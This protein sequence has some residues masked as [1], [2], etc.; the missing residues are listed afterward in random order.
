MS[1]HHLAGQDGIR[2]LGRGRLDRLDGGDA[3]DPDQLR[4][5]ANPLFDKALEQG[6]CVAAS[7][8]APAG[9]TRDDSLDQGI[10]LGLGDGVI[11]HHLRRPPSGPRP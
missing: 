10:D 9:P 2:L 4:E 8:V 3:L 11:V 1:H 7:S 5:R 6:V